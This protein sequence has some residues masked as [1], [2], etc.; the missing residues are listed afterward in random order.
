M[1]VTYGLY[2]SVKH[3]AKFIINQTYVD[4]KVYER[5]GFYTYSSRRGRVLTPMD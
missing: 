1:S 4:H 3:G 2:L 5:E